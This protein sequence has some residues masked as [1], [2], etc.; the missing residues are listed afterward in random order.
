MDIRFDRWEQVEARWGVLRTR[1]A[2]TPRLASSSGPERVAQGGDHGL[3]VG[4][5]A[6]SVLS[7]VA[8]IAASPAMLL[9]GR[10]GQGIS[11]AAIA[12]T[13]IALM[14]TTFSEGPRR[15]RV[16]GLNGAMLA[17]GFVLGTIG[18]G[19]ITSFLG[20]RWTM[21]LLV[22]MGA[23]ILVS[24]LTVLPRVDQRTNAR[25]DVPGA[26]LAAGGLFALVYAVS[27]ANEAGWTSPP[28]LLG[29]AASALMLVAF[30]LVQARAPEPLI[31]LRLL[32]R[33]TIAWG[34]L[35]GLAT[36]GLCG[37]TTILLSIYMQ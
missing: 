11:A 3:L 15:A 29:L 23:G 33:R 37:G 18:G 35:V 10:V 25:L 34:G 4:V 32:G 30:A 7:L 36:Y 6:F 24:A 8:A 16:L 20:W 31:P 17:F 1:H 28:I 9:V 12:P 22:V 14:T 27:T 19:L 21:A 2:S 5:A 26:V 13:A